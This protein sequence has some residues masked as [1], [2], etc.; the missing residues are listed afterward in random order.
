MFRGRHRRIAKQFHPQYLILIHNKFGLHATSTYVIHNRVMWSSR[1]MKK[2][3]RTHIY[4]G[5]VDHQLSIMQMREHNKREKEYI[6][7]LRWQQRRTFN[8]M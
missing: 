6:R 4:W 3:E 1:N 7:R 2:I 8:V 5:L